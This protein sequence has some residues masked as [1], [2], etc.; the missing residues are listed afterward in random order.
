MTQHY[1][2]RTNIT[3]ISLSIAFLIDA[4]VTKA[5]DRK[6]YM[7]SEFE[8]TCARFWE[9]L[10]TQPSANRTSDVISKEQYSA[11]SSYL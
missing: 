6:L 9:L 5:Y 7:H 10:R 11:V 1:S 2:I 3:R 8:S 4:V